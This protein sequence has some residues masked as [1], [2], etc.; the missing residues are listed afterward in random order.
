MVQFDMVPY[1]Y[2]SVTKFI[3]YFPQADE[4]RR[5]VQFLRYV[6]FQ[7]G[8]VADQVLF[9]QWSTDISLAHRLRL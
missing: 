6:L 2:V 3:F 8:A 7:A 9:Q 4:R 5:N 1:S